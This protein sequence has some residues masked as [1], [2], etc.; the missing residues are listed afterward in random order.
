[1]GLHEKCN[2][3]FKVNIIVSVVNVFD[4]YFCYFSGFMDSIASWILFCS[5]LSSI[6]N[7]HHARVLEEALPKQ[8]HASVHD[9]CLSSELCYN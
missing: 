6:E 2:N 7:F 8:V 5:N 1:M 9:C 3:L 4:C